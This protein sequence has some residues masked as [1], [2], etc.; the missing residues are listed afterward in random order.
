MDNLLSI[1]VPVYN[2]KEF[3]YECIESLLNQSYKNVEIILVDDGSTDG[4]GEICEE[5][6]KMHRSISVIHKENEGSILA[7]IAGAR[8]ATGSYIT[9]VDADDW[10]DETMYTSMMSEIENLDFVMCGIHRYYDNNHIDSEQLLYEEGIYN[11]KDIIDKIVPDML[12]SADTNRWNLDPSLCTKIFTKE[13]LM[14]EFERVKDLGCHFG[15]DSAII[16]P[17]MLRVDRVKLIAQ[18]HYYHR[19]REDNVVPGYIKDEDF[20]EKTYNLYIYL[21]A[22]FYKS[23]YWVLMKEQLDHFYYNAIELKKMCY[24]EKPG[25]LYPVF[26]FKE[27]EKNSDVILY[28]AGRVGKEY[29]KQNDMFHFSNIILWVDRNYQNIKYEKYKIEGIEKILSV[30]FEYILIAIDIQDSAAKVKRY[31]IDKGIEEKKIIWQN[32]RIKSFS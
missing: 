1:I 10:I 17:I 13:K 8:H 19:Q 23:G 32:T 7:R 12:W 16:F 15:D 4:S 5:Y 31:L 14:E 28:G 25:N 2:K 26:P 9:F 30:E 27:I 24:N 21:K 3:L 20:F 29:M 22:E 11:K 6:A 18:C